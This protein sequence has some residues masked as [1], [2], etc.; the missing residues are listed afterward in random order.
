MLR[1]IENVKIL[2]HNG[3]ENQGVGVISEDGTLCA[4]A[5][6]NS[7]SSEYKTSNESTGFP[8]R[9]PVYGD[10]AVFTYDTEK[11]KVGIKIMPET[12]WMI[13]QVKDRQGERDPFLRC[14]W[15][16]KTQLTSNTGRLKQPLFSSEIRQLTMHA[17]RAAV[18]KLNE[19]IKKPESRLTKSEFAD[20][21]VT[22]LEIAKTISSRKVNRTGTNYNP[23]Y[24]NK[25]SNTSSSDTAR[26]ASEILD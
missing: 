15:D 14:C 22:A 1:V 26:T 13:M 4:V 7:G 10:L 17:I 18:K 25:E 9:T 11:D 23:N 2:D 6:A 19:E 20:I 3:I 8:S 21:A 5:T 24:Y 16:V 12:N